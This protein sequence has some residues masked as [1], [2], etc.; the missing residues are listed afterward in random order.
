MGAN[1]LLLETITVGEAG[2]SSVTFNNIPQSGYTDL[3]I[4]MSSRCTATHSGLSGSYAVGWQFNGSTTGYS[5]KSLYGYSASSV[6]SDTMTTISTNGS[7]YGRLGSG[8]TAWNSSTANTFTNAEVYIPNYSV[9]GIAKSLSVDSATESNDTNYNEL[10]LTAALWTGTAPITSISFAP[11]SSASWMQ[12]STFSL[13]GLAAVGTTPVIAP[14]ASGGDIIQTDGTYWYHAFLSSGTFTPAKGLSCDYLVVAGGAGGGGWLG[15]GGGAGGLRSTVTA[16]GGGGSLESPLTLA[17]NTSYTVTVGAGGAGGPY[18]NPSTSTQGNNSTFATITSLGGGRAPGLP[19]G[20]GYSGGSGGGAGGSLV[21]YT[22][23][24]GTSGQGYAGGNTRTN[25]YAAAGGGGSGGVG[26][27]T[28]G[29]NSSN[30]GNGGNGGAGLQL[31]A[32][33]TPTGTGVSGYYAGGGGGHGNT[34]GGSG[35]AGGGAGVSGYTGNPGDSAT[36]NSG[37]G[38]GGGRDS[39]G[40]KGGSGIVIVRYAI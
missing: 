20:N 38:G 25:D 29:G 27:T 8:A 5:S 2:A 26:G 21:N 13:Y 36:P 3:K 23:G 32:F 6:G 24:A 14:Y 15:G 39:A 31:T 28:N 22:G 11:N 30:T 18:S 33:A 7:T 4:V 17:V 35:S 9:N 40:G 12:Y 16:T 1:Y 10:D 34:T 19:A 37:S